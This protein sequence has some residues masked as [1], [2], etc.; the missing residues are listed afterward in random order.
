MP[1]YN[2][3]KP[4]GQ[5]SGFEVLERNEFG[6]KKRIGKKIPYLLKQARDI[7]I[8]KELFNV[9]P[10]TLL[11]VI[12]SETSIFFVFRYFLEI[13]FI[14]PISKRSAFE[15]YVNHYKVLF[16]IGIQVKNSV[17]SV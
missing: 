3:K 10:E 4:E 1:Q 14:M 8:L 17:I 2:I 15:F 16:Q 13:R 7:E 12:Q 9:F 6:V 11:T 5:F